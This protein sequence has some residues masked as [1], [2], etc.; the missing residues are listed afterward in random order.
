MGRWWVKVSRDLAPDSSGPGS[1]RG[2]EGERQRKGEGEIGK[3]GEREGGR[4]GGLRAAQQRQ[5]T[6]GRDERTEGWVRG[7]LRCRV[8]S[9]GVCCVLPQCRHNVCLI[10]PT[11]TPWN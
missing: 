10:C 6:G 9:A 1:E 3:E 2:G 5:G 7:A 8:L 4:Q 11:P